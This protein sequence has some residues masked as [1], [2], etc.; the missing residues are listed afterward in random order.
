MKDVIG[1][2]S[3]NY[4]TDKMEGLSDERSISS[5]PFG[6]R[7][8]LVDFSLSNM[9]NSGITEVGLIT[10]YKFRSLLDHI[11]TGSAWLLD[12]KKGGLYIL[13]GATFGMSRS[14]DRFL[15][16]DIMQNEAYIRR[17][18]AD[19]VIVTSANI[20][21]SMD[22]NPIIEA[23]AASGA[24]LTMV[25]KQSTRKSHFL[26]GIKKK[27]G[28]V[29][30]IKHGLE[31]GE[32]AFLDTFVVG[33]ELL[34]KFIDWYSAKD[35]MD[36]FDIME[37]DYDKMD[38]RT[39]EYNGYS[40]EIFTLQNYF[41]FNMELL[42]PD[43]SYR[44]FDPQMPV[45]TKVQDCIPGRLLPGSEVSDSLVSSGC[46]VKGKVDHSILFRGVTVEE[47]AV[48]SNSIIMQSCIIRKDAVI[49][50]AV[51]DRNNVIGAG[52]IIKGSP[53]EIYV[54]KK[55]QRTEENVKG[56]Y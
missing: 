44:L 34:L 50:D 12:R 54:M 13:P 32:T 52:M 7:Y 47:G 29:T 11:G 30:G 1:L 37:P 15:L 38:I 40:R 35:Y 17:S 43:V 3:A 46:W 56:R 22:F 24:D 20:V 31:K 25:C 2:I 14:S 5:M 8:R 33:R 10:P 51:I 42:D 9:I 55:E 18:S 28:K 26:M 41:D 6:G 45:R 27:D 23:H 4:S 16:C 53:G 39:Y 36:I 48:V 19:Y 21:A 49:K